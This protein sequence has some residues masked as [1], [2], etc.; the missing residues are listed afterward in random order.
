M[1][2]VLD[3]PLSLDMADVLR[4]EEGNRLREVPPRVLAGILDMRREADELRLIRPAFVYELLPVAEELVDRIRL[5]DGTTLLGRMLVTRFRGASRIAA[6]VGTIGGALEKRSAEW[7]TVDDPFK[8]WLLDGIGN[9]ALDALS[10]EMC[11][12][13]SGL[14]LTEHLRA[15]GPLAPGVHEIPMENQPALLRLAGAERIGVRLNDSWMME[16]VKSISMLIGVGPDQKSW[17]R[18][19]ACAWCGLKSSCAYRATAYEA[20]AMPLDES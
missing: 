15:S 2:A 7:L 19:Q 12:T 16:P 20:Y 5:G 18:A 14:A 6:L 4:R 13:I 10:R 8:A 9:A 17:D 1:P 3:L 11:R